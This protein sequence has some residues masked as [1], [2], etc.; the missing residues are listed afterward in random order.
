MPRTIFTLALAAGLACALPLAAHAQ[1]TAGAPGPG[2]PAPLASSP[3]DPDEYLAR[4]IARVAMVDLR[5][6]PTAHTADFKMCAALLE[7]AERW[8]PSDPDLPRRRLEAAY[9]AGDESLIDAAMAQVVRVDPSDTVAQLRLITRRIGA[10]QTAEQRLAAYTQFLGERGKSLDPSIR[11][12]LALD[13]ALLHRERGEIDQFAERLKQAIS[14]DS[15]NKN[16]ALVAVSYYSDNSGDLLGRLELL[17]NLLLSDPTDPQ[18][19][20]R[21]AY[22]LCLAGDFEGSARFHDLA[23]FAFTVGGSRLDARFTEETWCSDWAA[24]G[25]RSVLFQVSNVLTQERFRAEEAKK[26]AAEDIAASHTVQDPTSVRLAAE[27]E[28][29]RLMT[30][31][32]IGDAKTAEASIADFASGYDNVYA[33][34]ADSSKFPQNLTVEMA[35]SF[36]QRALLELQLFRLWSGFGVDR[37]VP[38][39]EKYKDVALDESDQHVQTMR[40]FLE[41]RSGD[42]AKAAAMFDAIQVRPDAAGIRLAD[43]D[44]PAIGRAMCDEVTG[45]KQD[46]IARYREITQRR[47]LQ[48]AGAWARSRVEGLGFRDQ[49]ADELAA[50]ARKISASVPGDIDQMVRSPRSFMA[51]S[52][53][54]DKLTQGPF[55]RTVLHVTLRNIGVIPLAL[56]SDRTIN[57]RLMITPAIEVAAWQ[58]PPALSLAEIVEID[59][60]LRLMPKESLDITIWPDIGSTGWAIEDAG[61]HV[62]RTRYRIVQ[63]FLPTAAGGYDA[64]PTSL[65]TESRMI[66]RTADNNCRIPP[67]DL[68]A[69]IRDRAIPLSPE[70]LG[71]AR[72]R[73]VGTDVNGQRPT[74]RERQAI[75]A[76]LTERLSSADQK[77]RALLVASIPNKAVNP[78][79]APFDE[80]SQSEADPVILALVVATRV[81]D[82]KSP[83][84]DAAIRAGEPAATIAALQRT[85]LEAATPTYSTKGTSAQ[86]R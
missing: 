16:A 2:A 80:A 59:R 81:T 84:L 41:L 54:S 66:M 7:L 15:T 35:A 1:P 64:G 65:S 25:P 3:V 49:E 53:T 38:D 79:L 23:Q 27:L 10:S 74:E 44:L 5:S 55:E 67:I 36:R 43:L 9:S 51:M 70:T 17:S 56:G 62:V 26:A 69:R 83:T 85:R 52:V 24:R 18:I 11:S 75:V 48:L 37:V 46:A 76:A 86:L 12:R 68:A 34:L 31:E 20:G 32:A 63:G 33:T 22:D 30:A 47:P 13:A 8:A 73:L 82:P 28:R 61:A 78:E 77:T 72:S 40:A 42:P 6:V 45:H 21:M 71:A 39:L 50:A 58:I 57:S 60:R 14:L 4:S 19:L 29:L